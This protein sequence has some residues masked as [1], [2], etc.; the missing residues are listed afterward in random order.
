MDEEET[1]HKNEGDGLANGI[2]GESLD[3]MGRFSWAFAHT[4]DLGAADKAQQACFAE[5]VDGC[6]WKCTL[7][8]SKSVLCC[9]VFGDGF[10]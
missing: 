7:I 8:N 2:T 4:T 10:D 1:A 6:R 9:D 5:C 3:H